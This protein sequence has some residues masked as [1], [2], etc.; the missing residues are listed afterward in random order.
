MAK[1]RPDEESFLDLHGCDFLVTTENP[2]KA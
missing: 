2:V 1:V